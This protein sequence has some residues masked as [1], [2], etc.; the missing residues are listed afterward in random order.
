[1]GY[2]WLEVTN[3]RRGGMTTGQGA[4]RVPWVNTDEDS[5]ILFGRILRKLY[6]FYQVSFSNTKYIVSQNTAKVT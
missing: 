4:Y 3:E 1:M 2:D 5:S 6:R